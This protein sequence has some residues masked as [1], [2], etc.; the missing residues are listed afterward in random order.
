MGNSQQNKAIQ[1]GK[2]WSWL[3]AAKKEKMLQVCGAR[4]GSGRP[5]CHGSRMRNGE[6]ETIYAGSEKEKKPIYEQ[7]GER[8]NGVENF[9]A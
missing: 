4:T 3:Y 8:S 5:L 9:L 7:R 2:R 1:V 6:G